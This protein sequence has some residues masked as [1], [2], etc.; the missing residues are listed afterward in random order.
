MVAPNGESQQSIPNECWTVMH[1]PLN[2]RLLGR[3]A[4][5]DLGGDVVRRTKAVDHV[6]AACR[7]HRTSSRSCVVSVSANAPHLEALVAEGAKGDQLLVS[8][9]L[10]S[11][12]LRFEVIR[13]LIEN[14]TRANGPVAHLADRRA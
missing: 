11:S 5:R 10:L 13:W 4:P 14:A 12:R 2:V 3:D 9:E 8:Q 7:C 6:N 1:A